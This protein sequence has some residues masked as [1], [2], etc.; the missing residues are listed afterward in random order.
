MKPLRSLSRIAVLAL[1][2]GLAFVSQAQDDASEAARRKEL[3]AARAEL[4]RAA[5]RVAELSRADDLAAV[6][7]HIERRPMLGVLLAPDPGAGVR[8]TG[9]T[10]DSGAARAG[11]RAGDQLVELGGKPIPGAN[12][13]ARLA[14]ATSSLAKLKVGEPIDVTY[15]RGASEMKVQVAPQ[16]GRP[17]LVFTEDGRDGVRAGTRVVM[18]ADGNE[19]VNVDHFDFKWDQSD[20]HEM[21]WAITPEIQRE[22]LRVRELTECEGEHCLLPRL[23]EAY[24]WSGLNLSSMD[25]QLGRY[26][27]TERGVL[28]LSTGP[29]LTALQA[30]DVIQRIDGKPV[31]S[32]REVMEALRG[33][34]ADSRVNVDY[35]RDR[36]SA[37]VALKI[38]R[39]TPLRV[40]LP[41]M[42]PSP[43]APP[44]APASP[45][46]APP[47]PP[48]AGSLI[49]PPPPAPSA[50]K[51]PKPPSPP[52]V[53]AIG[54]PA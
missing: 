44:P 52:P 6:K 34:S 54:V 3:D 11:L 14:S 21:E 15:R 19:V 25:A 5:K 51:A 22:L 45:A 4:R 29:E 10:P 7:K 39:A 18:S 24:R 32:P 43:P 20:F 16:P 9:V 2:V 28:V 27:G 49:Q 42:P 53:P 36:H 1:A 17:V 8:I 46:S 37:T 30:G 31:S 26:F 48:A 12:A 38:P 13:E 50:P 23:T 41:P 40:P 33:R 47:T 35:L